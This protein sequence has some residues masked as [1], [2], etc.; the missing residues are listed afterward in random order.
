M[1]MNLV[2]SCHKPNNSYKHP[3]Q[4]EPATTCPTHSPNLEREH[5][6]PP[7]PALGVEEIHPD[8]ATSPTPTFKVVRLVVLLGD[9]LLITRVLVDAEVVRLFD[10][11]VDDSDHLRGSMR[12]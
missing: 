1:Y 6:I 3:G 2:E 8:T 5:V 7:A 11:R 10:V 12:V 9:D 4:A